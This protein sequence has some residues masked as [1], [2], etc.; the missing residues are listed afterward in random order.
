MN[1]KEIN[2]VDYAAE[3]VKA[4]PGGILLNTQADGKK[5]TMVIGWGAI[6]VNWGKP[7]MTVYVRESRYSKELLDETMEFTVSVP[8]GEIDKKTMF[9]VAGRQS[10]R[11]IDKFAEAGYTAVEGVAVS[12]PAIKELPLTFECKVLYKQD[13][14]LAL[15]NAEMNEKWYPK[16]PEGNVAQQKGD[17]H[18]TYIAEIVSAYILED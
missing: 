3:F 9:A 6:G 10:G 8:V 2:A 5:N 14:D 17:P 18:T 11:D 13:Q 7:V 4:L 15:L 1:R 12:T 16:N